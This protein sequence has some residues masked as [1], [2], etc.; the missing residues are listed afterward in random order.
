[1]NRV[2]EHFT[3]E[4]FACSCGCGFQAVDVDLLAVL[5]DVRVFFNSPVTITSAC[6][7]VPL[8]RA[9]GSKDSSHHVKAM[10]ADIHVKNVQPHTVAAYLE[11]NYSNTLG[12]GRY[13]DFTHIDVRETKSRW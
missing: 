3:K 6:R 10:A 7:C 1:M 4:E 11:T 9:I 8:N 5:E 12:I 2:S 13:D